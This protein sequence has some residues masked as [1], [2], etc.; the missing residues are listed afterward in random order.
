VQSSTA[1]GIGE[2]GK[3]SRV[4]GEVSDI[5]TSIAGA[6]EEQAA[7]TMDIARSI[8]EASVAV[9]EANVRV[10]ESSQATQS[11]AHEIAGVDTVT[12][13]MAETSETVRSSAIAL[14]N[15]AEQLQ[16]TVSRFRLA[17]GRQATVKGAIAAHAAWTA[18]LKAAIGTGK[19]DVPVQ[20]IQAD[21]QCQF[22]R[23][24]YASACAADAQTDHYRQAK[25]LH[26][27]FHREAA[28]VAQMAIAG[29]REPA[30]RAMAPASEYARISA[31]LT[32]ILTR[33]STAA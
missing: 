13:E 19:L 12:G 9:G 11:I 3:I 29:Q 23:W 1:G 21:D 22:G 15:L 30:E 6:I 24:L 5:V 28:K 2:I 8:G 25:Q 7:T 4:I 27:D 10:A 26:A 31:A 18:R 17:R 14:S 33:W 16:T 32:N 20:T